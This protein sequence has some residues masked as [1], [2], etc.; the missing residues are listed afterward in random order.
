[1]DA[2]KKGDGVIIRLNVRER[3]VADPDGFKRIITPSP[4][5][6]VF[7]RMEDTFGLRQVLG[8]IV[9][10]PMLDDALAA[11]ILDQASVDDLSK[12]VYLRRNEIAHGTTSPRFE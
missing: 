1:M 2:K 9:D 5:F 3:G 12:N 7:S 4:F 11:S 6:R 8:Q 10:Q